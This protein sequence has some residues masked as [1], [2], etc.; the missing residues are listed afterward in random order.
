MIIPLVV[1]VDWRHPTHLACLQE[2]FSPGGLK[3]GTDVHTRASG[4]KLRARGRFGDA[5][6]RREVRGVRGRG[7]ALVGVERNIAIVSCEQAQTFQRRRCGFMSFLFN[8]EY[9]ASR[10]IL[11]HRYPA[12]CSRRN[13]ISFRF[14]H[15]DRFIRFPFI[16]GTPSPSSAPPISSLCAEPA[17]EFVAIVV[18]SLELSHRNPSRN[19]SLISLLNQFIPLI[20][21]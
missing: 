21:M 2:S 4:L 19:K 16:G 15:C 6:R 3:Q 12:T 13:T 9:E 11:P 20:G 10:D 18:I 7:R 17:T 8:R 14:Y 5:H 1:L